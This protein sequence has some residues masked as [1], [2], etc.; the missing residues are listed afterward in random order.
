MMLDLAAQPCMVSALANF[1]EITLE[2]AG[3]AES[4]L[5]LPT[6]SDWN[7]AV[8]GSSDLKTFSVSPTIRLSQLD[9]ISLDSLKL[10]AQSLQVIHALDTAKQSSVSYFPLTYEHQLIGILHLR[11]VG[12]TSKNVVNALELQC[13]QMALMLF[14]SQQYRQLLEVQR[15]APSS[16]TSADLA[17]QPGTYQAN[18]F[19][20]L[21]NRY[22]AAGWASGQ[23]LYEWNFVRNRP[24]WGPN[25]E[26]ILG[27]S[28]DAMPSNFD[29]WSALV[30][31]DDLVAFQ[32]SVQTS[33]EQRLPLRIEYRILHANGSYRWVE[34]RNH[35]FV[36][37]ESYSLCV[38][39]FVIDIHARKLDEEKLKLAHAQLL[40]ANHELERA[41]RLK[42]EFLA[43]MSHELRTPLNSILG[44]SE[45]LLDE[46]S[47]PLNHR[48]KSYLKTVFR[49]GSHLLDLIT[50]ILSVAKIE[51]GK[52]ELQ[53]QSV[54]VCRLCESSLD[55]VRQ[56]AVEKSIDIHFSI[57]E[58]LDLIGID[59]RRMRQVLINLLSNAIKFTESPG[60]IDVSVQ[61]DEQGQNLKF[62]V[63]DTG[64]GI[65]SQ[66]IEHLF[67][68]FIQID[69][70]LSRNYSG[71]GLGLVLVKKIA[72][73]HGGH[74]TV[75]SEFGRGSCFSVIIP[76]RVL[77]S[78][79]L[80]LASRV[81]AVSPTQ[82]SAVDDQAG[83]L[84]LLAEDNTVN[85]ELVVDYLEAVGYRT[86]VAA[87]GEAA[88]ELAILHQPDL[89]VIDI[90]MPKKDGLEV[91]R[92]LRSRPQ[93]RHKP[94]IA[95]TALAM[96]QDQDRCLQAGADAYLPK[97]V[98]LKALAQQVNQLLSSA[99]SQTVCC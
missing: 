46:I 94:I 60:R 34:D 45:I 76:Y 31:P 24:T 39:G 30:H 77:P 32:T 99:E 43:C 59:K 48:Q 40:T 72:E 33:I 16:T 62:S 83:S 25:T 92:V 96:P 38:V 37:P 66:D 97:P 93:L 85:A 5:L 13:A 63:Q 80:P 74:V 15:V 35:V 90:Q 17:C 23:I 41:T 4:V 27:Y 87:D 52:L 21:Q 44:V 95:L 61:L 11:Y 91:M 12:V 22:E 53:I 86:I 36:D 1:A 18:S 69:S 51:A 81:E 88:I 75:E 71:T 19:T 98:K 84:I 8:Y 55:Y 65:R 28:L 14:Q 78:A 20:T 50:D 67:Q 70:Q 26:Q 49:S 64:I 56:S 68:P 2:L 10:V 82:N 89:M 6:E 7:V 79:S 42:D 73:L 57:A 54:D 9:Y 58:Q 3:A 29:E 47:G